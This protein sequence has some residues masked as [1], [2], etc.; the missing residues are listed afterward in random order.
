MLDLEADFSVTDPA[1]N[2]TSVMETSTTSNS[3]DSGENSGSEEEEGKV[4]TTR[5]M[6]KRYLT[7]TATTG[8]L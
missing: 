8:R 3:K 5:V 4:E 6:K 2:G 7:L 1:G